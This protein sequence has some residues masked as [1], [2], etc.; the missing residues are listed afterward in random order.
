MAANWSLGY[1]SSGFNPEASVY[2]PSASSSRSALNAASAA[3]IAAWYFSCSSFARR[4]SSAFRAASSRLVAMAASWSL[5]YCSSGFRPEASVYLLCARSQL[6]A[7]KATSAAPI[8]AR[9]FSCSSLALRSSSAFFAASSFFTAMAASWSFGYFSSGFSP[10]ASLYLVVAWSQLSALKAA[11]AAAM[12][13]WYFSCSSFAL[14][15]SSAF[16]ARSARMVSISFTRALGCASSFSFNASWYFA[17]AV[18]Y[19]FLPNIPSAS[20]ISAA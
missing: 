8:A 10:T 9:Y 6:E 14:R 11:S 12:A 18:S 7:L 1:F 17:L 20:L 4:S 5:G 16:F 2:L 13:A 19:S 3:V 15:S